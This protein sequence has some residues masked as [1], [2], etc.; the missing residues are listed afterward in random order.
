LGEVLTSA[1]KS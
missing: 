1:I